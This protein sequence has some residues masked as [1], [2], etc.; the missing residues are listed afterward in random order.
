MF[1]LGGLFLGIVAASRESGVVAEVT[2]TSSLVVTGLAAKVGTAAATVS[3]VAAATGF[4]TNLSGT[5]SVSHSHAVA[6]TGVN[7]AVADSLLQ[8]IGDD[9]LLE[10]GFRLL[11]E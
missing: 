9:L 5:A 6:A 4:N 10:D 2:V 1:G 8:E 3:H 11:L 7:G